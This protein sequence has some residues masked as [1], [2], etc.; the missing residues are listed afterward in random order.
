MEREVCGK[1]LKNDAYWLDRIWKRL[2]SGNEPKNDKLKSAAVNSP[3]LDFKD[4]IYIGAVSTELENVWRDEGTIT[5]LRSHGYEPEADM[6]TQLR[7][8]N[9]ELYKGFAEAIDIV[10]ATRKPVV[11]LI[12]EAEPKPRLMY[13][14]MTPYSDGIW[15]LAIDLARF[16]HA[17]T[18]HNISVIEE[19]S[20]SMNWL[21]RKHS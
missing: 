15:W 12:H 6:M 5:A 14:K 21:Q 18:S 4:G 11:T 2:A 9:P 1:E 10:L 20:D 7:F 16:G 3:L 13:C 8:R 19:F 17:L